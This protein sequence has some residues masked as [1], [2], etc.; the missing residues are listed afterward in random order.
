MLREAWAKFPTVDIAQVFA[1][2]TPFFK[3]Y[4]VYVNNFDTG[5][6]VLGKAKAK[7]TKLEQ[8]LW[9]ARSKC[10]MDLESLMIT[11]IQRIPRYEMMLAE[12]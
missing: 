5:L 11:P 9:A 3:V 2:V 8:F 6:A 1:Q 12:L 7:N 10:G 4:K